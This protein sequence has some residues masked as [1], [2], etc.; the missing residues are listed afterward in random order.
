MYSKFLNKFLFITFGGT[1]ALTCFFYFSGNV[2]FMWK[3]DK[4]CPGL[5]RKRRVSGIDNKFLN[6]NQSLVSQ[7]YVV[8]FSSAMIM[9]KSGGEEGRSW[10]MRLFPSCAKQECATLLLLQS[11]TL[12]IC[13][14]AANTR[15][16]LTTAPS[17]TVGGEAMA[18][19]QP[20]LCLRACQHKLQTQPRLIT[21][22]CFNCKTRITNPG[23]K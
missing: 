12:K 2:L 22:F 15:G 1:F 5:K 20:E 21:H 16:V 6:Q 23:K 10:S 7:C 13:V 4:L 8:F 9:R 11:G 17:I 3:K 19:R 18:R 14:A